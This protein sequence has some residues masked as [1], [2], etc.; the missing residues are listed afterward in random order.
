MFSTIGFSILFVRPVAVVAP[1]G[2]DRPYVAI[3]LHVFGPSR[4]DEQEREQD[5][6]ERDEYSHQVSTEEGG[7]GEQDLYIL[8]QNP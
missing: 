8:M 3:E 4:S 7:M 2:Q 1:S 6:V 5:D